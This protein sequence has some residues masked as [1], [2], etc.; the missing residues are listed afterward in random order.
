MLTEVLAA[1]DDER[2]PLLRRR[3]KAVGPDQILAELGAR[4]RPAEVQ[5]LGQG[6]IADDTGDQ[7]AFAVG[8]K[9]P[10]ARARELV[11]EPVE[12][13]PRGLDEPGRRRAVL[14]ARQP[15]ARPVASAEHAAAP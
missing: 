1:C 11:G 4:Q 15:G 9:R 5:A 6:W 8:E 7:P 13:R 14:I 12:H 10:H 2:L 3:A